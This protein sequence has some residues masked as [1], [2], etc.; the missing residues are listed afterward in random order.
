MAEDSLR[1]CA[2]V[3]AYDDIIALREESSQAKSARQTVTISRNALGEVPGFILCR[4]HA[5]STLVR[6]VLG[7]TQT[8]FEVGGYAAPVNWPCACLEG[9]GAGN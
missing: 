8:D 6:L 2:L 4:P 9:T 1:V 7:I 5:T 3:Y